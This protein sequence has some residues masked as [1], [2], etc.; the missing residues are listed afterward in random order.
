MLRISPVSLRSIGARHTHVI[1]SCRANNCSGHQSLEFL[2]VSEHTKS[3][4]PVQRKGVHPDVRCTWQYERPRG[5]R[6]AVV[7]LTGG[8]WSAR[9]WR[10]CRS[11][12]TCKGGCR[13]I[14][15]THRH[16]R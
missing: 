15:L 11:R 14:L 10:N 7:G 4:L 5:R 2:C 1:L 13:E 16:T 3:K 12:A 9:G 8:I 6:P